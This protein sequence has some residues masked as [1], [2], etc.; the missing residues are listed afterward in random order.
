MADNELLF[1]LRIGPTVR[2]LNEAVAAIGG[3]V[4][5][6]A[7]QGLRGLQGHLGP[8]G[9]G[10][11][12]AGAGLRG[13]GTAAGGIPFLGPVMGPLIKGLSVLPAIF[14][15]ITSSLTDMA[16]KA[17]PALFY[18][19]SR[20][21]DDVQ[22]VI[23]RTFLPV[24]GMMRDGVRLF[25]DVLANIL[26]DQQEVYE[27]LGE[28]RAAFADAGQ[29][30]RAILAE[31]GPGIREALISGLKQLAHW[32]AVAAR[33][34]TILAGRPP[35]A[36]ALRRGWLRLNRRP[37]RATIRAAATAGLANRPGPS[38]R[39]AGSDSPA[40]G[41]GCCRQESKPCPPSTCSGAYASAPSAPSAWSSARGR[42]TRSATPNR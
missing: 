6:G 4:A 24:L 18:S 9:L 35:A 32:A 8:V 25:G 11:D 38:P 1:H 23:G 5:Y 7:A 20:A 34:V 28:L 26:P 16:H 17:S 13:L 33:A 36:T 29:E 27:A 41:G 15:D 39:T 10:F 42:P 40:A 14:K 19:W 21:L 12:V 2:G 3:G 22:G 31:V 37:G 30:V